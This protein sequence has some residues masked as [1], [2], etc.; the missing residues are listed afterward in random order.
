MIKKI[1]TGSGSIGVQLKDYENVDF[2]KDDFTITFSVPNKKPVF[3][4]NQ[5]FRCKHCGHIG[6]YSATFKK[7]GGKP[8]N[9]YY[10]PECLKNLLRFCPLMSPIERKTDAQH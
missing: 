2:G 5:T 9:K 10:C 8:V 3:V 4:Y 7:P 6:E 1:K